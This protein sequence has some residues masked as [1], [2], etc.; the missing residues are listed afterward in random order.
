MATALGVAITQPPI[1]GLIIFS[2]LGFG[3]ALPF[4]LLSYNPKL[5]NLLPAPG[6]WMDTLKQFFAYPLFATGIWLLWVLGR[7]INVDAAIVVLAGCLL[8]CFAIWLSMRAPSSKVGKGIKTLFVLALFALSVVFVLKTPALRDGPAFEWQP[9][10]PEK[11]AQLRKSNTP[12]FIDLTADWCIT[13]KLNERVALNLEEVH[14]KAEQLGIVM[15]KG[16]WTNADPAITEL[17]AEYGRN[18]VPLYLMYPNN[19]AEK[20]F[21]LPQILTKA[22]VLRVMEESVQ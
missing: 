17:L 2:S 7:Q 12:V 21:V 6:A 5:V 18:G 3:M 14:D 16:D 1:V 13:C 11:L 20:A 8:I 4:L 22:E 9:Y 15:M 19:G 10:T